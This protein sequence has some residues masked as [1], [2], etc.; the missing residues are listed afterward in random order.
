MRS[1]FILILIS[2][3]I[4]QAF[5]NDNELA[6][7]LLSEYFNQ[8]YLH[9]EVRDILARIKEVDNPTIQKKIYRFVLEN[10]EY[11]FYAIEKAT[12]FNS[13]PFWFAKNHTSFTL[14][15]WDSLME[16]AER[17]CL[18]LDKKNILDILIQESRNNSNP[19][20]REKVLLYF[21]KCAL[22]EHSLKISSYILKEADGACRSDIF[23]TM[24]RFKHKI[25]NKYVVE[26]LQEYAEPDVIEYFVDLGIKEYN[27]YDFLPQLYNLKK[28]L[29]NEKD[30][31][32]ISQ[33]KRTLESL[34]EAIP[35]LEKKKKEGVQIGFP[36]DYTGD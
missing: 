21:S 2:C 12:N 24:C 15:I 18:F 34:N 26:S 22:L 36:L 27:R 3:V 6:D 4:L 7:Q 31:R 23:R 11:G 1:I 9:D 8:Y 16:K 10:K 13:F 19:E 20:I 17:D 5:S 32:K 25:L 35:Y 28:R 30:I 14:D 29:E 33:A